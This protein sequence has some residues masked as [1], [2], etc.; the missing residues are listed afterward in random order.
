MK[1]YYWLKLK[2]EFFGDKRLKALRRLDGGDTMAVIFLR[3]QLLSLK[4]DGV[5]SFS[6]ICDTVADELALDLGEDAECVSQT[7]EALQRFGLAELSDNGTILLPTVAECVGSV[8]DSAE[9]MRRF[10]DKASQ[11]DADSA[12][13][14][15]DVTTGDGAVTESDAEQDQEPEPPKPPKKPKK[16]EPPKVRYAE[17][18]S[19][20]ESDYEKLVE[21]HG[22]E[23]AARLVEILDNYKG[24]SGKRYASDYRAILNWAV[25]RYREEQDATKTTKTAKT[26]RDYDGGESFV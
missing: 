20:A 13:S 14:D 12:Q 23:G 7:I 18:V 3:M 10:R 24:S 8:T 4:D 22:A 19:M 5:I 21:A 25:R 15:S 17:F 1:R 9:R 6:G 2:E 16:E 11:C 26:Q